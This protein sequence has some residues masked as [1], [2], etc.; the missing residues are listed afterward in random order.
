MLL[1]IIF[2][3]VCYVQLCMY[4]STLLYCMLVLQVSDVTDGVDR[5]MSLDMQTLFIKGY[6]V[7]QACLTLIILKPP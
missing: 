4:V 6:R 7:M 2:N 5:V 3:I 1:F